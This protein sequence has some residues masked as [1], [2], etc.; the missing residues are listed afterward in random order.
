[1]DGPSPRPIEAH[2][3]IFVCY[4]SGLQHNAVVRLP[5]EEHR[6]CSISYIL[7]MVEFDPVL[8]LA[9]LLIAGSIV[10]R[11]EQAAQ[12]NIS[13]WHEPVHDA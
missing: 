1:M 13:G 9:F 11:A 3:D 8:D 5:D 7:L 4:L 10:D 2:R 6:G 12:L